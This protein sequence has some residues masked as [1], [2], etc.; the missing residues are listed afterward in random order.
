[1]NGL[2][3]DLEMI[4]GLLTQAIEVSDLFLKSGLCSTRGRVKSHGDKSNAKNE[5]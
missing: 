2:V 3:L 1:M 5:A 4:V